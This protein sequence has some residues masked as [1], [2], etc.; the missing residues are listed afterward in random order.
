MG[1]FFVLAFQANVA[2]TARKFT[3][4]DPRSDMVI[5]AAAS[6]LLKPFD[7]RLMG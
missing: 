2:C 3:T 6:D 4:D 1:E 7:A 5:R